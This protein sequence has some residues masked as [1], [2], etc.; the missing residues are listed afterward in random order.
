MVRPSSAMNKKDNKT[1][2]MTGADLLLQSLHGMGVDTCFA[3]P[4]TSEMQLVTA[5][6][7]IDGM[8]SVL[9]LFEGVASG[10]A[11][12]YARI[13]GK[14]AATLLHLGPGVGNAWAN[15]HNARRAQVPLINLIGDH[16]VDHL[17]LDA[18]LTSDL[19]GVAGSV[20]HALIRAESAAG[21][22][23][24][25]AAAF[26]AAMT[27]PGQLASLV[28][29]ADLAWTE[30]E[31][32]EIAAAPEMASLDPVDDK[33]IDQALGALKGDG[34]RII[35]VGT[36]ITK[37][38]DHLRK[39]G[40]I[41]EATGAEVIADT[42]VAKTARGA[43]RVNIGKLQYFAE[44]AL[45]QLKGATQMIVLGTKPPVSFFAYP[46]VPSYLVPDGCAVTEVARPGQDVAAALDGLLSGLGIDG[47]AAP[48]VADRVMPD[49]PE[50]DLD[51]MKCWASIAR[52]MPDHAI[53]AEEA[54]TSSFGSEAFLP[55]AGPFDH[56]QLTGGSI[57][58][59]LP[60]A[61]GAAVAAPDRKVICPHG[62][63]GAMYTI[64][65][66]WT[67]AREN[68][69]V[70]T[71]IFAN[72]S[73]AILNVELGRVG[74]GNLGRKALDMLDIGRPDLN[75][76]QIAKGMGVEAAQA[77]T[78]EEFEDLMKT[79]C[80]RRGPFLIEAII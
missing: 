33:A 13:A 39:L 76:T 59:G 62:D 45:E 6:D 16:A 26:A 79:A 47:A 58:Y 32:A 36:P 71:V 57:G 66:L 20:S 31:G 8:R 65:S 12:G 74:A 51:A 27:P 50:G 14:P 42:F 77:R 43:G 4:G 35:F 22:G 73:Y 40:L 19:D 2:S 53:M 34:R 56:L 21:L 63:G 67:M 29:P 48:T 52:H 5:I 37:D 72:R 15:L 64:Q 70:V 25:A 10:A 68:L 46:N 60:V 49:A 38:E 1:M 9:A 78:G 44:M 18:P 17:Q 69:D 41:A 55:T 11:D 30:L 54:A 3:N 80:N 75:F 61:V 24:A 7:R 28:L 23:D